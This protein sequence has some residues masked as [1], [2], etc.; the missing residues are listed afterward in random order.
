VVEN[1]N[2]AALRIISDC[3]GIFANIDFLNRAERLEIDHARFVLLPIGTKP[4]LQLGYR[5][6]RVHAGRIA[7]LT[8]D[9]VLVD[10]DDDTFVAC[11]R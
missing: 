9:S 5:N 7:D 10:V 1:V 6:K 11:E 2:F 3:V 8:G 4:A